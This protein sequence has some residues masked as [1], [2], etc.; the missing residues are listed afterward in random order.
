M[1]SVEVVKPGLLTT[2]QDLGRIGFQK[3]GVPTSGAMD[4]TALRA[5]NLL[6][7]NDEGAAGLEATGEGPALRPLGDVVLAVVGATMEA[8]VDGRTVDLGRSMLVRSGHL[9]DLGRAARGLRAYVAVAGGIDVPVVLGSRSTCLPAAFGGFQGRPLRQG[10]VLSI[11][12]ARRRLSDLSGRALPSGWT[13][14][15]TD[16]LTLRVTL[17]PQDDRFTAAGIQ[18]FLS[19]EYRVTAEIDRMGIRLHGPPIAHRAGA[20]IISDS[21][22]WGAVQIPPDGQPIV[23]LADRQTTGGYAKIA[24]V[25]AEDADRLAQ[26]VPGQIVRFRET[27]MAEA[28]AGLR[29]YEARLDALRHVGCPGGL[30]GHYFLRLGRADY[31]IGVEGEGG[32]YR[33]SLAKEARRM[34]GETGE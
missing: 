23:L 31:R 27:S 34:S 10:D 28:H 18:T 24:V 11:G 22:P 6:V 9:I 4:R 20:D 33:I 7:G 17:G 16:C 3:F 12:P 14:P 5:A 32:T 26:A 25:I 29:A 19:N 2:V 8:R 30:H 13:W 15:D 21:I 1:P